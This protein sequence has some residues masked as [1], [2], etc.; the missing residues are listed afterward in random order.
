VLGINFKAWQH[1]SAAAQDDGFSLCAGGAD[2]NA[3]QALVHPE[4]QG[5]GR[6]VSG[7]GPHHF[8]SYGTGE[9][10]AVMRYAATAGHHRVRLNATLPHHRR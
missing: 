1:S 2:A 10:Q 9:T 3:F 7:A 5:G 6:P 8:Y 4:N